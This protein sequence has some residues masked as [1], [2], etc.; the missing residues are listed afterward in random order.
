MLVA[1]KVSD[2]MPSMGYATGATTQKPAAHFVAAGA[3][4]FVLAGQ[5]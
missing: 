3:A 5:K 2:E 1:V 4:E